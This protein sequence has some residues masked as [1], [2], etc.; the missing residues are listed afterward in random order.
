MNSRVL[1]TAKELSAM[2]SVS[3]RTLWR[4]RDA[5][6]LPAPIRIGSCVRWETAAIEEWVAAGF[7]Q[8]SRGR[9]DRGSTGGKKGKGPCSDENANLEPIVQRPAYCKE[10][11]PMYHP[12]DDIW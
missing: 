6:R 9:S 10:D 8:V 11:D 3:V 7:P 12:T 5:G 4:M 1:V 2:L